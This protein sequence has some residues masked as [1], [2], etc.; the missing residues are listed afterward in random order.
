M[1]FARLA[2]PILYVTHDHE[3]ALAIGDR[4]AVMHAGRLE[5]VLPPRDLW[6]RPPNEFVARFLGFD[7]IVD[8]EV[9][10]GVATTA[11]GAVQL[12]ELAPDGRHRL[13]IRPDAL[14]PHAEWR[15]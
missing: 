13:L 6:Q 10:D 7:N 15:D 9:A 5:A 8:A 14:R 12:T 2:L 3:E 1:L 4:V 11:L